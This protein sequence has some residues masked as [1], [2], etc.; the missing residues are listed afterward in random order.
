MRIEKILCC[1]LFGL[2]FVC[3]NA[4]ATT[5]AIS[6]HF[7]NG[8]L[9]PAWSVSFQ[10]STGWLYAESGT[11]LT[12]TDIIPTVVNSGDG[13]PWATVI[14]SRT[15]V[16]LTDFTVDFDFSWSSA[17]SM[18]PMQAVGIHLYDSLG[19]HIAAAEY[20]DG[21]VLLRGERVGIAGGNSVYSG[22]STMPFEGAA[23]VDIS[24]AGDNIDVL[25]DGASVVSGT[26]SSPIS[27]V[28][29]EFRY[30]AYYTWTYGASFFDSESIDFVQVQ[31]ETT[32]TIPAPGAILL[33]TLGTG[34]VGWMRRRRTL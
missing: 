17:G 4:R 29:L 9:D 8:V 16:P 30:Y 13:G 12:V 2:C 33:G 27:R 19:N 1:S 15:F 20:Q 32:P 14:L 11:S 7:N 34:L 24:R 25:W 31:G 22:H 28:D 10:N 6:D 18:P 23:S 3:A 5:T 21:W 26:S